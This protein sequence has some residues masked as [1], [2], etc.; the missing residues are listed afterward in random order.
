MSTAATYLRRMR[1]IQC[2]NVIAL[3][4]NLVVIVVPLALGTGARW[5]LLINFAAIGLLVDGL[6]R[7]HRAIRTL[8]AMV[9]AE[10]LA[11]SDGRTTPTA[12]K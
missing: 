9:Q 3:L 2:G 7:S 4:V 10:Q 1:C 8:R 6:T 12:D 11:Q 5:W